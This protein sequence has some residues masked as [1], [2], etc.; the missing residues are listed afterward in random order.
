MIESQA[1]PRFATFDDYRPTVSVAVVVR[2][3]LL[4][5]WVFVLYYRIDHDAT[6]VVLQAIAWGL[7]GLN[8]YVTWRI[9]ARKPITWHY[10]TLLGVVDLAVITA[11]LFLS[12]GFDNPYYGFYYPALLGLA[13]VSPIRVSFTVSTVAIALYI[14]M[15]FTV[16]PALDT[17]LRHENWLVVR[18]LTMAGMVV[19]GTLITGWERGR[20]QEAVA[21]E[22]ERS[23]EN[24]ELQRKAQ[25]AELAAVEERGHV[26]REIHDGIA[27]SIYMLSLHL[28]TSA[29]L[30]RQGRHDLKER[31]E[32]LVSLS[33][34]TLLEVRHYIFDLK[35]Y[36]AGD[37]GL[38]SMVENQVREFNNVAR[39]PTDVEVAGE[40]RQVP[41]ALATCIY[42]VTQEA[43]SNAFKHARASA[44]TLRLE[45]L[46]DGMRFMVRDDGMGFDPTASASGHGLENMRQR[47]EELG[48]T[49]K[50]LSAPGAGTRIDIMLPC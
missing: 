7:A 48:G 19:A 17:D 37:K 45:F 20:R 28:E 14:A 47:A 13:L 29:E 38:V 42:R 6:W 27:Q 2:W 44:V 36:L 15:V 5:V 31:L 50:L 46:P 22:R 11:A 35:P 33:K 12:E 4:M 26:A 3:L 25:K 39:V 49:F 21:A 32:G 1:A 40:E 24:L 8:A 23:E 16:S 41:V 30:A 18:V 34:E 43:L 10:A 9:L